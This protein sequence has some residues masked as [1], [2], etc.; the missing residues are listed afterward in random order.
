MRLAIFFTRYQMLSEYNL[1]GV[2][3]R[4]FATQVFS[5]HFGTLESGTTLEEAKATLDHLKD[6]ILDMVNHIVLYLLNVSYT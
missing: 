5:V 4:T 3:G 2:E 6:T 1:V